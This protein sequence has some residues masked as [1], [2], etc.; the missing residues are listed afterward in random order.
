MN[1]FEKVYYITK[2]I[3]K[4]RVSTYGQIAS[5]CGNPRASRAVGY[6]LHANPQPGVIPCHRIVNRFGGLTDGFAFGGKEIQKSL[7]VS[8][9]VEVDDFF[10]V[11]LHRFLWQSD[12]FKFTNE[13]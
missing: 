3:P 10:Q 13:P 5:L 8:E 11:D 2:Q 7:L 12:S 4:G 1:F 9:G 6:A